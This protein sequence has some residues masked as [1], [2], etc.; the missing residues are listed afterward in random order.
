MDRGTRGR[1]SRQGAKVGCSSL[2]LILLGLFQGG[3]L[4]PAPEGPPLPPSQVRQTLEQWNPQY[5]KVLEFYGL[6]QPGGPTTRMAY[7]LAAN[8][9]EPAAKPTL[10]VA[11]FQLL[12]RPDGSQGWFLTSLVNHSG[13]LTRRQGWDNLLVPLKVKPEPPA[14][15]N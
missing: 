12:T 11:Q 9:K 10:Y 2:I 5:F 6:H 4:P 15:A 7:V 1:Q 14:S 13:G 8:P 3:C